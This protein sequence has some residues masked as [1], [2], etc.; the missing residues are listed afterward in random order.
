MGKVMGSV[1]DLAILRHQWNICGMD[2][3]F[4]HSFT[5]GHFPCARHSWMQP[6]WCCQSSGGIQEVLP[7]AQPRSAELLPAGLLLSFRT[8]PESTLLQRL[9]IS[10]L[11][12]LHCL[13]FRERGAAKRMWTL[14]NWEEMDFS[15]S[16]FFYSLIC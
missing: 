11:G 8:P 6:S 16:I 10:D 15:P 9:E 14:E 2:F 7:C 5:A 4:I 3:S 13:W 12:S 1:W